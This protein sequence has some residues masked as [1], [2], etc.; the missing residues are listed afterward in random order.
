MIQCWLAKM[1]SKALDLLIYSSQLHF[2]GYF[3]LVSNEN[4]DSGYTSIIS[5]VWIMYS[6]S[7]QLIS[8]PKP[9]ELNTYNI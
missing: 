4:Y 7:E 2:E 9:T 3:G 5:K 1:I 6:E 8:N